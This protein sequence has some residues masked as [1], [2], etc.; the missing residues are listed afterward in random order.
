MKKKPPVSFRSRPAP[1]PNASRDAAQCRTAPGVAHLARIEV[2]PPLRLHLLVVILHGRTLNAVLE[3]VPVSQYRAAPPPPRGCAPRQGLKTNVRDTA[4]TEQSN[5]TTLVSK[6]ASSLLLGHLRQAHPQPSQQQ[7]LMPVLTWNRSRVTVSGRDPK[8]LRLVTSWNGAVVVV[9]AENV[10]PAQRRTEGGGWKAKGNGH[11]T[12]TTL[13][14]G[15][16]F[17]WMAPISIPVL[18]QQRLTHVNAH[19][20]LLLCESR[21]E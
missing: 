7:A 4:R 3:G 9:L 11:H 5:W 10:K 17:S 19:A 12:Q 2:V 18:M 13:M 14:A 8:V 16:E 20:S 21:A 15:R 6:P 1:T